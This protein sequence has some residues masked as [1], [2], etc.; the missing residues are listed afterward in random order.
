MHTD[1]D[2]DKKQEFDELAGLIRSATPEN[3]RR[4]LSFKVWGMSCVALLV[5][6]AVWQQRQSKPVTE[7]QLVTLSNLVASAS[8][9]SGLSRQ[10]VWSVVHKKFEVRR[11]SQIRQAD[12]ESAVVYLTAY[13]AP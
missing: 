2:S 7:D 1:Q 5:A 9:R 11:A 4:R 8:E 10:R 3:T 13:P 6:V 12:F